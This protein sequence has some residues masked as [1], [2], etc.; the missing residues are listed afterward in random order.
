MRTDEVFSS[1]T[2]WTRKDVVRLV[3][4]SILILQCVDLSNG[5]LIKSFTSV[6]A[7][8][9]SYK[10][11]VRYEDLPLRFSSVTTPLILYWML[12]AV[13]TFSTLDLADI[14][15]Y[16]A[17]KICLIEVIRWKMGETRRSTL[18]QRAVSEKTTRQAVSTSGDQIMDITQSN[19][20]SV[21][22]SEPYSLPI[23]S[24][25]ESTVYRTIST[26]KES[27]LTSME[28]GIT[29]FCAWP[30]DENE[31]M[32]E[33]VEVEDDESNSSQHFSTAMEPKVMCEG[34]GDWRTD[35][36]KLSQTR[37]L[38]TIEMN[39]VQSLS[40]ASVDYWQSSYG[41]EL[42]TNPMFT[43]EFPRFGHKRW[44]KIT[45]SNV[46]QNK[47]IWSL[48]SN[49]SSALMATPTAGLLRSGEHGSLKVFMA[50]DCTSNG[51]IEV[52]YAVVDDSVEEFSRDLYLSSPLKSHCLDILLH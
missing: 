5:R 2:Q 22:E 28:I 38:P 37:T 19:I 11:C 3:M 47:V 46:S 21:K 50:D 31:E 23:S 17:L 41:T 43:L 45:L 20:S 32:D 33:E 27:S 34:A 24:Q 48:R 9:F 39:S 40:S 29:P 26:F 10:L 8:Y 13:A 16:I 12:E 25:T 6:P 44:K 36:S 52:A 49:M 15:L 1:H 18:R 42:I 7:L 35:T 51:K 30:G 4:G 14:V